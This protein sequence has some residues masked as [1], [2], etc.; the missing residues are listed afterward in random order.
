MRAK[1]IH[2][3]NNENNSKYFANLGKWHS[4]KKTIHILNI[5]GKEI[6]G[7]EDI[8]SEEKQYYEK[9]LVP[10]PQTNCFFEMPIAKQR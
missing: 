4:E 9:H 2:V 6:T 5:N 7:M 1:P 10:T 3:E 8:L